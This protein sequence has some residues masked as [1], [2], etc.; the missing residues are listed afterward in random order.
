LENCGHSSNTHEEYSVY[1]DQ[2]A[3]AIVR[4][5]QK[6]QSFED[7][8]L[9]FEDGIDKDGYDTSDGKLFTTCCVCCEERIQGEGNSTNDGIVCDDCLNS[10]YT[11]CED[12]ETY[13]HYDTHDMYYI[14]NDNIHLCETCYDQGDY[15]YCEKTEQYWSYTA[16]IILI[17][18]NGSRIEVNRTW[19]E[20]N[21]YQ[22]HHCE[23]FN[24]DQLEIVDDVYI[25]DDCLE[26]YYVEIDGEYYSQTNQVA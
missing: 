1:F 4:Y 5:K 14:E 19:A 23:T 10:N 6:T 26:E 3:N 2:Q 24:E 7:L 18:Y 16:R 17:L 13:F 20:D 22:C 25:C 9:T 12:C 15:F 11:Y 21:A 8:Y